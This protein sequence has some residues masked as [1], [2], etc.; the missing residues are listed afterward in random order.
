MRET[1][2][3]GSEGGAAQPNAPFLP[4]SRRNDACVVWMNLDRSNAPGIFTAS[5]AWNGVRATPA[6][7]QSH[8]ARDTIVPAAE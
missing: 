4:L 5:S 2:L 8:R 7:I 3:S 6:P 1:R